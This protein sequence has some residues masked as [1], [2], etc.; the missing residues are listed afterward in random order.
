MDFAKTSTVS[1]FFFLLLFVPY[2][3]DAENCENIVLHKLSVPKTVCVSKTTAEKLVDRGWGV[4]DLEFNMRI[5]D[6][7]DKINSCTILFGLYDGYMKLSGWYTLKEMKDCLGIDIPIK[8]EQI[9]DE[10]ITI[11]SIGFAY[12]PGF[13]LLLVFDKNCT[14]DVFSTNVT[15]LSLN[16]TETICYDSAVDYGSNRSSGWVASYNIEKPIMDY[17]AKSENKCDFLDLP[18]FELFDG[19]YDDLLLAIWDNDTPQRYVFLECIGDKL[20]TNI[21]S[22]MY[23]TS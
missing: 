22:D 8:Y 7:V 19:K 11:T 4:T 17:I 10:F 5:I 12:D 16:S 9:Q 3:A 18:I 14:P 21:F 13:S 6:V 1:L 15:A 2:E 20:D 23:N